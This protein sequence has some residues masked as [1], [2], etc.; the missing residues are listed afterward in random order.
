MLQCLCALHCVV[1]RCIV[2]CAII[3][4]CCSVL[5]CVAV[6]CSVLQYVAV[7][8]GVLQRDAPFPLFP[9][10]GETWTYDIP[11]P[12]CHMQCICVGIYE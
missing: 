1:A 3:A 5:Q 4:V 6:C 11:L 9:S 12:L 10:V 7:R 2:Q 8:C